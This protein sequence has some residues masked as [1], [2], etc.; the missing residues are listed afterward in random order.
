MHATPK[1]TTDQ[2]GHLLIHVLSRH[3]I[4]T[5]NAKQNGTR[6]GEQLFV[7]ILESTDEQQQSTMETTQAKESQRAKETAESDEITEQIVHIHCQL[8]IHI[9]EFVGDTKEY[10]NVLGFP[11]SEDENHHTCI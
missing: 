4:V 8:Q 2:S 5:N 6:K 3:R 10:T 7:S 11:M 1:S 9:R